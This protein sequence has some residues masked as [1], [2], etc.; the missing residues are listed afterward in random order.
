LAVVLFAQGNRK[1]AAVEI[2]R[3]LKLLE[4]NENLMTAKEALKQSK[5]RQT[6]VFAVSTMKCSIFG[7]ACLT[8]IQN[9]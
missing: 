9:R 5:N 8:T 7:G 4:Q 1:E 3:A 6:S 2:E